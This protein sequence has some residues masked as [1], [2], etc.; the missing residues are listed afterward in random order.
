ML[1]RFRVGL[2]MFTETGSPNNNV[3][4][5]YVRAAVRDLTVPYK[6]HSSTCWITSIRGTT[7]R[8]AARRPDMAEAYY[9]FDGAAAF[10]QLQVKT[11]SSATVSPPAHR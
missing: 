10:G 8:T 11:T 9:Y 5:G 1:A 3:D 2:M 7:D 6:K 4:G